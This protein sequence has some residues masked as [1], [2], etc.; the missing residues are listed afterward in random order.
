MPS[1][2]TPTRTR[3]R[4]S[5]LEARNDHPFH[6]RGRSFERLRR[7]AFVPPTIPCAT[8]VTATPSAP[9]RTR[10]QDSS[11]GP[12]CDRP[13]H[14]RGVGARIHFEFV[15]LAS[16]GNKKTRCVTGPDALRCQA[17]RYVSETQRRM[18]H[19]LRTSSSKTLDP[20]PLFAVFLPILL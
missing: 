17:L 5:S 7:R 12:R 15:R 2:S 8:H 16:C 19:S 4:N 20:S 3:T 1:P 6:H 13:F 11:L 18:N 14:H 9:T 10:T